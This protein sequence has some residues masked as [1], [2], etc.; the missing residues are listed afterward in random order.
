[1][2]V[3]VPR[4]I[5]PGE[6]RVALTPAVIPNLAKAGL[7]VV[8]EAGAGAEAGYPDSE[9]MEKGARIISTAYSIRGRAPGKPFRA[10]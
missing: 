5:Y 3:C 2:I 9:Y 8:I 10:F 4:E 7:Q 1:M 6:R